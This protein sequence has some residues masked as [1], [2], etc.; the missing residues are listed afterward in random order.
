M[1]RL[2][3]K[4]IELFAGAGL[5]GSAFKQQGFDLIRAIELDPHAAATYRLNLGKHIEISDVRAIKPDGK[6]DVIIAGPP[7]QGFS[8]LGARKHDDPRNDLS[9]EIVKW[10]R[11]CRPKIIV[12][13]NVAAFL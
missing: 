8:T 7:C 3:P 5:F 1:S 12:I 2:G 10:A 11:H 4:V 9:L 6:C 13:E